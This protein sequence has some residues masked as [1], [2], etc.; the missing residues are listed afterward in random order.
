MNA[1]HVAIPADI[2]QV[3]ES[4]FVWALLDEASDP[5][6]VTPGVVVVAGDPSE[7]FLAK[8]VDV[9]EK[10]GR[11]VVHL[12]VLAEVSAMKEEEAAQRRAADDHLH[13]DL[14]AAVQMTRD[15]TH[16]HF[17]PTPTGIVSAW[18]A[19]ADTIAAQ[20]AELLQLAH[21]LVRYGRAGTYVDRD[22]LDGI[23][24]R[25][26]TGEFGPVEEEPQ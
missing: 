18:V 23:R 13:A 4:G 20:R 14:G 1:P 15:L 19:H 12:E 5:T 9:V 21:T 22:T 26:E 6:A 2:Q 17:H 10:A 25:L 16:Q 24:L 3:D 8:V 7:P 11:Q